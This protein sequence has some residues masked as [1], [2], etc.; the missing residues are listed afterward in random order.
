[1]M[2]PWFESPPDQFHATA[3]ELIVGM[4]LRDAYTGDSVASMPWIIDGIAQ[5]EVDALRVID[6]LLFFDHE[7]GRGF[8]D[9]LWVADGLNDNEFE[10][11]DETLRFIASNDSDLAVL[12]IASPWAADGFS[13][14]EWFAF[15]ILLQMGRDHRELT[16]LLATSSWVA[17][18]AGHERP[19]MGEILNSFLEAAGKDPETAIL[20]ATAPWVV[21]GVSSGEARVIQFVA[22]YLDTYPEESRALLDLPQAVEGLS[23]NDQTLHDMVPLA[24]WDPSAALTV[25]GSESIHK[26]D[27]GGYLINS[28][29]GLAETDLGLFNQLTGQP[30]FTDGLDGK[31]AA[32][33]VTLDNVARKSLVLYHDLLETRYVQHRA[34]SLPLAGNVDI[35]VVQGAPPPTGEDL[36]KTVENTARTAEE[37]LGV[38]FPT[39][40]IIL[41]VAPPG[42]GLIGQHRGSHMV[43]LR[44]AGE[45]LSVPHETAHYYFDGDMGPRWLSE[46]AAEFIEAYVNDQSGVQSLADRLAE[47]VLSSRCL[48]ELGLE[49]IRHYQYY[50]ESEGPIFH[51]VCAHEMGEVLLLSL[52]HDMGEEALAS[53]LADL[54]LSELGIEYPDGGSM[55]EEGVYGTL[56]EH[57]PT[58][59]QEAFRDLYRRLHGG[60]YAFPTTDFSDDH[61]DEPASASTIAVGRVIEGVLD[62]MFD[63]DYFRFQAE[64]GVK[65]RMNVNHGSLPTSGVTLYGPDGQ[66][67]EKWNW[68]SRSLGPLGPQILWA[69][70]S[71]GHYYFAVHN[72]GGRSGRYTLTVTATEDAKDDHGDTLTTATEVS[73]RAIIGGTIDDAFDYDY[74]VFSAVRGQRYLIAVSRGT[75]EYYR[76]KLYTS[77]G[78]APWEWNGNQFADDS[79]SGDVTEWVAPSSGRFYAAIEG[80]RE[81]VGTYTLSITPMDG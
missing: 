37:F 38:P 61:G 35:W 68:K 64:E 10:R 34:V 1:M 50:L 65:Y 32:S 13:D 28:M 31:E 22:H 60:P 49:N 62:Y 25:A 56:L 67:Q 43:L 33:I 53:A 11:V 76:M 59:Q 2:L 36:L 4:W 7:L 80:Y 26:T 21:D 8:V 66:T 54:Y 24:F 14:A 48:N 69:A 55:V 5:Q 58:D 27:L 51:D 63:F 12:L 19:S 72:F 9:S 44:S 71:S 57:T 30:W 39:T 73:S 23:I 75:L 16:R 70:P 40:D 6:D 52:Y 74:F 20:A 81:Y 18:G 45:V 77:R 78:A 17:E 15:D 79:V 41:L 42:Y 29:V 46:G 47:L 3:S